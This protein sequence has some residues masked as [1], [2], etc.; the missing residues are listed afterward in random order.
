MSDQDL[1]EEKPKTP[2]LLTD[3]RTPSDD[4]NTLLSS[5]KNENG[6]PKYKDVATALKALQASQQFI[7]T[8]KNE[9]GS[10]D[11][12]LAQARAELE[13][14]G[15]IEDFVKRI[16]NDTNQN[17]P[18][19]TP[20]GDKGLSAEDIAKLVN[21]ELSQRES[22]KTREQNLQSVQESLVK[23]FG[24]KA[25][26]HIKQRAVELNTTVSEIKKL[27]ENNPAM[28]LSLL[29]TNQNKQVISPSR[30][31]VH[32]PNNE[33]GKLERPKVERG[34]ARGGFTNSQLM[35]MWKSSADYTNKRLGITEN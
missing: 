25:A 5:I 14:M 17:K 12:Q 16:S 34:V 35:E 13:K 18:Q 15:N 31:T 29:G 32:I 6:E 9:K 2:D 19:E 23:S 1:F 11:A 8:L 30:G 33:Q 7:E 28:A 20:K 27:A 10:T 22:I 4:L 21:Q 26:D 3:D 24:D